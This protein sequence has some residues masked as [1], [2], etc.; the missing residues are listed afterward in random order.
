MCHR[1]FAGHWVSLRMLVEALRLL[2]HHRCLGLVGS[3]AFALCCATK[4]FRGRHCLGVVL[5]WTGLSAALL[6]ITGS[7]QGLCGD[8]VLMQHDSVISTAHLGV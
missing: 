1:R 7:Q 8:H 3:R 4:C 5:D 6:Y 2:L